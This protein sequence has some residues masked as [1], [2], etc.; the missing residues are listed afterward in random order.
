MTIQTEE[1]T[2]CHWVRSR[3]RL[4]ASTDVHLSQSMYTT[5]SAIG[6]GRRDGQIISFLLTQVGP[7]GPTDTGR[8][9]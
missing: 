3:T 6:V 8:Y 7:L 2:I 4:V 1:L 9:S 5:I